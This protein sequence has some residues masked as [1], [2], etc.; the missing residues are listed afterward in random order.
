M[1]ALGVVPSEAAGAALR[2]LAARTPE[3]TRRELARILE[4]A[5]IL[6][7]RRLIGNYITSLEMAGCSITLVKA[8]DELLSLWDDPVLTPGL[9]WGI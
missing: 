9:R 7:A 1:R 2:D 8:G 3:G 6:I 4:R 5:G